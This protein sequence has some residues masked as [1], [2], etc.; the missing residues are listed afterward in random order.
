[1]AVG[2]GLVVMVAAIR[3]A[4]ASATLLASVALGLGLQMG[5]AAGIIIR[6]SVAVT[7]AYKWAVP[8]TSRRARRDP[9]AEG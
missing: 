2:I 1:M 9:V 3:D 4:S 5:Y 7:R 8:V 6:H